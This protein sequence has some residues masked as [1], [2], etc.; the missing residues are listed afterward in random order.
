MTVSSKAQSEYYQSVARTIIMM[1]RSPIILSSEERDCIFQWDRKKIP[2]IVVKE[3]IRRAYENFSRKRGPRKKTFTLNYCRVQVEKAF[4]AYRER[5]VGVNQRDKISVNRKDRLYGEVVRFLGSLTA[6]EGYLK[7]PFCLA[8]AR[9]SS[10]DC[11]EKYLESLD[12]EVEKLIWEHSSSW[13][14]KQ[15]EKD[16]LSEYGAVDR[17]EKERILRIKTVKSLRESKKIPYLSLF[18]YG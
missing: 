13:E 1:R 7:E 12:K 11:S 8:E 5:R 17:E 6:T 9:L 18:Y 4:E 14:K 3:G 2:L 10:G 16:I 15:A